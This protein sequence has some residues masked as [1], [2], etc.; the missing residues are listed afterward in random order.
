MPRKQFVPSAAEEARQASPEA[1]PSNPPPTG[2]EGA[3]G[4]K[5]KKKVHRSGKKLQKKR[6]RAKA[7]ENGTFVVP[8]PLTAEEERERVQARNAKRAEKQKRK[9]TGETGAGYIQ[10]EV[11]GGEVGEK[12][13]TGWGRDEGIASELRGLV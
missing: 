11:E 1:G 7:I 2:I 9:D 6:E 4:E 8:D 10:P 3:E 12:R 5:P 13:K